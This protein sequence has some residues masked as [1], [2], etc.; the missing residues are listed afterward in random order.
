VWDTAL[1]DS[2]RS[3]LVFEVVEREKSVGDVVTQSLLSYFKGVSHNY[4][5]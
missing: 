2:A 4:N 1:L 3:S 5:K